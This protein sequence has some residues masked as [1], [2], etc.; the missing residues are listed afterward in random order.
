LKKAFK[1]G[2][3]GGGLLGLAIALGMDLIMGGTIGSG[4]GGWADAVANDL[5]LLFGGGFKSSDFIVIIC[6][7]IAIGIMVLISSLLGGIFTSLVSGFF[8]FM[9]RKK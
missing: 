8:E 1:Y 4:D 7:F 3:I 9:T 6:V 5:N 2:A